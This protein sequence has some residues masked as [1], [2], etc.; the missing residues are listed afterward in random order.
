MPIADFQR[1]ID[2]A[3]KAHRFWFVPVEELDERRLLDNHKKLH[4]IISALTAQSTEYIQTSEPLAV[5]VIQQHF[6]HIREMGLRKTGYCDTAWT[7]P[8]F[9]LARTEENKVVP[10]E[11]QQSWPV[12]DGLIRR[13][14]WDL[15]I[16]WNGRFKGRE[17]K[18]TTEWLDIQTKYIKYGCPHEIG[19]MGWMCCR[20]GRYW[21]NSQGGGWTRI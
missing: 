21:Y 10:I 4:G 18:D 7:V 1:L 13:D 15:V 14:R 9:L 16:Q 5:A 12:N 19:G 2:R 17:M 3:S 20:C 6:F 8:D 11:G